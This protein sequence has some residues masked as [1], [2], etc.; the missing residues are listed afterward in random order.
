MVLASVYLTCPLSG[1]LR[2]ADPL[3][4]AGIITIAGVYKV[5]SCC[6]DVTVLA[7]ASLTCHLLMLLLTHAGEGIILLRWC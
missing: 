2:L 4:G 3:S 7:S 1:R 6:V 5:T